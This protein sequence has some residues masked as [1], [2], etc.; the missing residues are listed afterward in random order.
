MARQP[1]EISKRHHLASSLVGRAKVDIRAV[2][3]QRLNDLEVVR[4]ERLEGDCCWAVVCRAKR[5]LGITQIARELRSLTTKVIAKITPHTA[6][7]TYSF[8]GGAWIHI[9]AAVQ[10]SQS[11]ALLEWSVVS[12]FKTFF[13]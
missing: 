1:S 9:R 10:F 13:F 5:N 2:M 4:R 8:V 7:D 11:I 6:R 3:D 12:A